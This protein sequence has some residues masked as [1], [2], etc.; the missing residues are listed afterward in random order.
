VADELVD[1][2]RSLDP[3]KRDAFLHSLSPAELTRVNLML[4]AEKLSRP[5]QNPWA[6]PLG[7]YKPPV[8][9]EGNRASRQVESFV[10]KFPSIKEAATNLLTGPLGQGG[11]VQEPTPDANDMTFWAL[12]KQAEDTGALPRTWA[13]TAKPGVENQQKA[14]M[15]AVRNNPAPEARALAGYI[16]RKSLWDKQKAARQE[17]AAPSGIEQTASGLGQVVSQFRVINP[18]E[19]YKNIKEGGEGELG[20]LAADLLNLYL[21]KRGASRLS[22][23]PGGETEGG[24][25]QQ[26]KGATTED[27]PAVWEQVKRAVALRDPEKVRQRLQERANKALVDEYHRL[28]AA[29]DE[30][31][32]K[33]GM[34]GFK[35]RPYE[36]ELPADYQNYQEIV[37]RDPDQ[38]I[39]LSLLDSLP[40]DTQLAIQDHAAFAGQ[41][42]EHLPEQDGKQMEF[43]WVDPNQFRRGGKRSY[44]FFWPSE[45]SEPALKR[46]SG[47]EDNIPVKIPTNSWVRFILG[48]Q[49]MKLMDLFRKKTGNLVFTPEGFLNRFY[50]ALE[51]GK[52]LHNIAYITAEFLTHEDF[53]GLTNREIARRTQAWLMNLA[54]TGNE[55]VHPETGKTPVTSLIGEQLSFISYDAMNVAHP[56][57][58]YGVAPL[59]FTSPEEAI[60]AARN[61]GRGS[62]DVLVA[63]DLAK[64]TYKLLV[65]KVRHVPDPAPR[66]MTRL[67]EARQVISEGGIWHMDAAQAARQLAATRE[68]LKRTQERIKAAQEGMNKG[69]G[70]PKRIARLTELL[71]Q[72]QQRRSVLEGIVADLERRLDDRTAAEAKLKKGRFPGS[73]DPEERRAEVERRKQE[74]GQPVPSRYTGG[75][76][77]EA[78]EQRVISNAFA[79]FFDKAVRKASSEA[80]WAD[81]VD[82]PAGKMKRDLGFL[83]VGKLTEAQVSEMVNE[84]IARIQQVAHL[85]GIYR[86]L[87]KEVPNGTDMLFKI[88]RD[89]ASLMAQGV[90]DLTARPEYAQ[91]VDTIQA[92]QQLIAEYA[93]EQQLRGN[94]GLAG[95]YQQVTGRSLEE[96]TAA[97]AAAAEEARVAKSK[98]AGNIA[99][100]QGPK[101]SEVAG[102]SP[103]R[104]PIE[105]RGKLIAALRSELKL[106]RQAAQVMAQRLISVAHERLS[107]LNDPNMPESVKALL[108][109]TVRGPEV[110]GL[111]PPSGRG[112]VGAQRAVPEPVLRDMTKEG[113]PFLRIMSKWYR[114][115]GLRNLL[116]F[117]NMPMSDYLKKGQNLAFNA[118]IAYRLRRWETESFLRE[119]QKY[120]SENNATADLTIQRLGYALQGD[121]PMSELSPAAQH[122]AVRLR[123]FML[124]NDEMLRDVYGTGIPLQEAKNYLTQ[125]WKF[126]DSS[127][128]T[129]SRA[130]RTL[131]HD[132]F[133]KRKTIESYKVGIEQGL[134][135]RYDNVLDVLRHRADFATRAAV[136]RQTANFLRAGGF[137]L[138]EAEAN[139]YGVG[140]KKTL[141][142]E[143][144]QYWPQAVDSK[145]LEQ[146]T[147]IGRKPAAEGEGRGGDVYVT[148]PVL[149]HPDMKMAVDTIFGQPINASWFTALDTIRAISKKAMLI[150]FFHHVALSEVAHGE[151]FTRAL[152]VPHEGQSHNIV[153]A[154][155]GTW[156]LDPAMWRGVRDGIIEIRSDGLKKGDPPIFSWKPEVVADW[157]KAG[158]QMEVSDREAFSVRTMQQL[159]KGNPNQLYRALGLPMRAIGHTMAVMDR[160]LWDYF[161][162]GQQLT[163][164]ETAFGDFMRDHPNATVDEQAAARKKIAEHTNYAFGSVPWEQL[165]ASPKAQQILHWIFLAPAWTYSNVRMPLSLM[166]KGLGRKLAARWMIGAFGAWFVTSQLL[167]YAST[168]WWNSPDKDGK[169]GGHFTWDNPGAPDRVY[170]HYV[171]WS[172]NAFNIYMG[173]FKEGPEEYIRLGKAYREMFSWPLDPAG[174]FTS[175]V[176][177]PVRELGTQLTGYEPG[178]Y[179]V[180]RRD[181]PPKAKNLK[182]AAHILDTLSPFALQYG[183]R[184]VEHTVF[185]DVF[186][187]DPESSQLFS[188]PTVRGMTTHRASVAYAQ[189][190]MDMESKLAD[191]LQPKLQAALASGNQAEADRVRSQI[192]STLAEGN[193]YLNQIDR[194]AVANFVNLR[195]MHSGASSIIR[196]YKH[197]VTPKPMWVDN[198]GNVHYEARP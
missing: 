137:I 136:N 152:D 95:L 121:L 154:V 193:R 46:L 55:W 37:T 69:R 18:Y 96:Q 48:R 179:E 122:I 30:V 134:I 112:T 132:P 57:E 106:D 131:M 118:A 47:V 162:P 64:N 70:S 125:I 148:R 25:L 169:K 160:G 159:G 53:N 97:S 72:E 187:A 197:T 66:A 186:P 40:P 54:L 8:E 24:F 34:P 29:P 194:A 78:P 33:Q 20:S 49:S 181:E 165:L 189:I 77:P 110:S 6:K 195:T 115:G 153:K 119:I 116:A 87:G 168:R 62:N 175:K 56:I 100:P 173:H 2:I 141:R 99:V 180:W 130:Y 191:D 183:L 157:I 176:S 147:W 142:G 80:T 133:L 123:Q 145:S 5:G 143:H 150:G 61:M 127:D 76:A 93:A 83:R 105:R 113:S 190:K 7:V 92:S 32:I 84:Y 19:H 192:Q 43:A 12:V 26:M 198:Y 16:S 85:I 128:E 3:S 90:T 167:N 149:V 63:K 117:A 174:T 140:N 139:K 28:P 177:V 156:F 41:F 4:D 10:G 151:Y 45:P 135:P 188:Q 166:E 98:A 120:A 184:S 171:P 126:P 35:P 124:E 21:F 17:A 111:E 91:H 58:G 27:L 138:S 74:A 164:M 161:L 163:F 107:A 79:E 1:R 22:R 178:G 75:E 73:I 108:R 89:M 114:I 52:Q 146:A 88:R 170:G 158:W 182:R 172:E 102:Y 196:R 185:P 59:D 104:L 39:P 38:L 71:Q 31:R 50:R 44:P 13:R 36:S 23:A 68:V 155:R 129:L 11:L 15:D 82:K 101:P 60:E 103:A 67:Q 14:I 94:K 109:V 9:F 86:E 42:S 51:A 144:R 81:Q 65:R